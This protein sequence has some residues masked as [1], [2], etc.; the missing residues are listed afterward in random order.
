MAL[1]SALGGINVV[2]CKSGKDRTS[3]AVTLEEGRVLKEKYGL[4]QQQVGALDRG[5]RE[6]ISWLFLRK[7]VSAFFIYNI[8]KKW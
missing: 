3:M 2:A 4:S 8:I 6:I 7:M 5:S 1:T